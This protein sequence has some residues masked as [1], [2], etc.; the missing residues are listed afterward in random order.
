MSDIV[1]LKASRRERLGSNAA[2]QV[3]KAGRVPAV[4]YGHGQEPVAFATEAR[5]LERLLHTAAHVVEIDLDGSVE[6]ALVKDVQYDTYGVR[7][8]HVDFLRVDVTEKV[9]VGVALEYRGHP[10]GGVLEK[11]LDEVEIRVRADRIPDSLAVD[12]SGLDV[13]DVLHAR[14]LELPEGAEL[15]TDPDHIVCVVAAPRGEPEAAPE[16]PEEEAEP[17]VVGEAEKKPE[18][19]GGES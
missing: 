13:E 16:A 3:R 17:E 11:H 12:V 9:E 2:R 14:D 15:A 8:L 1:R 5:E 10:K 19:E 4:L 7:V 6:T 18:D